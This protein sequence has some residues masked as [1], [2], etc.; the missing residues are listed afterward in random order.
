M[1]GDIAPLKEIAEITAKYNAQLIVDE[2]H[3]FGVFGNGLVSEFNLQ[4]KFQQRL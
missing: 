4:E 2:A 1:D 3:A